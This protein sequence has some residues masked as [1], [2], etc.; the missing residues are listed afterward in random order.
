[1]EDIKIYQILK[2]DG[3][4]GLQL[5]IAKYYGLVS[6]ICSRILANAPEDAEE[7]VSESFLRLWQT[8]DTIRQPEAMRAYLCCIARNQA[9][10]RYRKL[11]ESSALETLNWEQLSDKQDLYLEFEKKE[12]AEALHKAI[13]TLKEPD[14]EIFVRKYFYFESMKSIA[15][16]FG[17]KE[18]QVDNSLYRSKQ[19]LRKYL[20]EEE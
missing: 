10:S 7:C 5:C 11:R 16:R 19:R 13:M 17:L 6:M 1:M 9:L 18:K 20:I 8:L 12:A 4:R 3:K 14:R 2:R 15:S